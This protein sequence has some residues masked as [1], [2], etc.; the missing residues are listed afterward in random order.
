M[1]PRKLIL[2][3][4]GFDS[5]SGGCPSPIFPDGTMYSL[6]IPSGGAQITYGD[7]YYG[8]I[9]IGQL[10]DDLT[11]RRYPENRFDARDGV[12]L[13]PDYQPCRLYP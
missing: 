13:D 6:P 4:K 7:L 3:R 1:K 9:N 8:D 12:H 5:A 10:V 2:S 11:R